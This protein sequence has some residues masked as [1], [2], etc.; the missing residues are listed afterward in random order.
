MKQLPIRVHFNISKG[1]RWSS[2]LGSGVMIFFFT[3]NYKVILGGRDI[4][5]MTS[6]LVLT[7]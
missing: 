6:C 5:L 1:N 7:F 4:K 2:A 3:A